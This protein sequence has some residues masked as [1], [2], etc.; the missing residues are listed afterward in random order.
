MM[1]KILKV[2]I[3]NIKKIAD[4]TATKKKMQKK[5]NTQFFLSCL[6]IN[7]IVR[8]NVDAIDS[9]GYTKCVNHLVELNTK[10]TEIK[11]AQ[12]AESSKNTL[13]NDS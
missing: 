13:S 8:N 9:A 10:S 6:E 5:L 4:T 1:F 7:I 3:L 12:I 2:S 11:N